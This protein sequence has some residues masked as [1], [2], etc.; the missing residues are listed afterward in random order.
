MV[1]SKIFVLKTYQS[2]KNTNVQDLGNKTAQHFFNIKS[3]WCHS[4]K[5][6]SPVVFSF[7]RIRW[8][9]FIDKG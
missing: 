7:K 3:K 9:I 1:Y 6:A 5:W 8:V 2:F 4:L